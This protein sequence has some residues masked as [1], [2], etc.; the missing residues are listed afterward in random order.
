[1]SDDVKIFEGSQIR[2]VWDNERE[3]WYFSVVD[4]IGSLTEA[5]IHEIIGIE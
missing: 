4:V 2:S 1:M 5:I 3:E